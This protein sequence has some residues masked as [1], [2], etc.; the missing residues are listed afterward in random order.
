MVTSRECHKIGTILQTAFTQKDLPGE[1]STEHISWRGTI[2]APILLS[3]TQ[4]G[5]ETP[6]TNPSL[7]GLGQRGT[8]AEGITDSPWSKLRNVT[9]S[10]RPASAST[11]PPRPNEGYIFKSSSK[12]AHS[13]AEPECTV[14]TTCPCPKHARLRAQKDF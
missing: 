1:L 2:S 10:P 9:L 11:F 3:Q 6:S 13:F 5:N 14:S 7:P 4:S 12:S 8:G